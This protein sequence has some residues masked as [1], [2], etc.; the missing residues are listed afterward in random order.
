MWESLHQTHV[1]AT[2]VQKWHFQDGGWKTKVNEFQP[3][4]VT[5]LVPLLNIHLQL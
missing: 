2:H 5:R 4:L 3:I 1:E